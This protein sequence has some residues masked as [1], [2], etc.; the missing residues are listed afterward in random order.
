MTRLSLA[1]LNEEENP[2]LYI[3]QTLGVLLFTILLEPFLAWNHVHLYLFFCASFF[4]MWRQFYGAFIISFIGALYLDTIMNTQATYLL[5]VLIQYI[6]THVLSH[7]IQ[8]T[9]FMIHWS[10]LGCLLVL[11]ECGHSIVM[12]VIPFQN[13]I[14]VL[15][16]FLTFTLYP[17]LFNFF[18]RFIYHENA[19]A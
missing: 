10:I 11:W 8:K 19:D 4:C 16:L 1:F 6:A 17:T 5:A 12:E 3:K 9:S 2:Y 15:S 7:T 18:R 13:P 14:K